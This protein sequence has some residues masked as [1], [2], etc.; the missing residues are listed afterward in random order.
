MANGGSLK[1]GDIVSVPWGLKEP[2]K[3]RII[4]V[5]GNPPVQ[6][7]VQLLAYDAEEDEPPVVL[8]LS[9]SVVTAA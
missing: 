5:W 1:V 9:A 6:V 4:D 7:R 2:V 3:A 8:L